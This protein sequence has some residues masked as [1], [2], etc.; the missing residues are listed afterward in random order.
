MSETASDAWHVLVPEVLGPPERAALLAV[1][2]ASGWTWIDEG[3]QPILGPAGYHSRGG[4]RQR[5]AAIEDPPLAEA[6]WAAVRARL[7]ELTPRD[8]PVAINPR[9]RFY[10]YEAG[11]AYPPHTDGAWII[12]GNTRSRLTLLVYLTEGYDGGE[13]C[14]PDGPVSLR[15]R[16]G[17][18]LLFPHPRWH[19]GAPVSRGRKVVLRTD[20]LTAPGPRAS[21]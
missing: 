12:D 15:P 21:G 17:D 6:L 9:L 11:C 18:A 7:P 16:P 20:L 1:A 5:R 4:R 14:F 13:T 2:D 8:Q 19:A 10:A 3:D